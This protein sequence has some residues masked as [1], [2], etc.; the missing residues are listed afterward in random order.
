MYERGTIHCALDTLSSPIIFWNKYYEILHFRDGIETERLS[1]DLK[2]TEL[3]T[4]LGFEPRQ[5]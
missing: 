1:N 2:I 5:S 3:E 4:N